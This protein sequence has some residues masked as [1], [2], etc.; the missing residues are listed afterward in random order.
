MLTGNFGVSMNL[1]KDMPVASLV[2]NAAKISF[3]YGLAA[4]IIGTIIGMTLGVFAALHRNSI[5]D[6]L[7]TA[8]S[9]I[10]VSIPSFVFALLILISLHLICEF[11]LQHIVPVNQFILPSCRWLPFPQVL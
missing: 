3:L 10:G 4:V 9:V 5:W 7:A 1:Y 11:Y 2:G 6:T 8:L